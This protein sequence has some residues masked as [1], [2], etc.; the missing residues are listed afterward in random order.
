MDHISGWTFQIVG[1]LAI[2]E[3]GVRFACVLF[4]LLL[5]ALFAL[6]VFTYSMLQALVYVLYGHDCESVG[7]KKEVEERCGELRKDFSAGVKLTAALTM[8]GFFLRAVWS[9]DHG[10]SFAAMNVSENLCFGVLLA[11][12]FVASFMALRYVSL[13]YVRGVSLRLLRDD[14]NRLGDIVKGARDLILLSRRG[15]AKGSWKEAWKWEWNFLQSQPV[16]ILLYVLFPSFFVS[17]VPTLIL[18]AIMFARYGQPFF[19]L[20]FLTFTV[21]YGL[22][23]GFVIP[24]CAAFFQI[25][26]ATSVE[27]GYQSVGQAIVFVLSM[28]V[29][30]ATDWGLPM[31]DVAPQQFGGFRPEECVASWKEEKRK[32]LVPPAYC[33]RAD[34]PAGSESK[35]PPGG[36]AGT[37]PR[38]WKI[39]VVYKTEKYLFLAP[40]CEEKQKLP[41]GWQS[42]MVSADGLESLHPFVLEPRPTKH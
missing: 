40:M 17:L 38:K 30:F 4:V 6:W 14:D 1:I 9:V 27:Y 37:P 35:T 22:A 29:G 8:V 36:D 26:A 5:F 7:F 21:A 18:G 16:E 19:S 28:L 20:E 24:I 39:K 41:W 33:T 31:C 25:L 10:I 32:D 3:P 34:S 15:A 12:P 42:V 13:S 11:A 2:M 23:C